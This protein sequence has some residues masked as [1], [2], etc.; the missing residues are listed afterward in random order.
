MLQ[1]IISENSGA[2]EIQ[3]LN[4]V[5]YS[6]EDFRLFTEI[7]CKEVGLNS[8]KKF[9]ELNEY[10]PFSIKELIKSLSN[11]ITMHPYTEISEG[12]QIY[13]KQLFEVMYVKRLIELPLMING[14][15][16]ITPVVK[17]RFRIAK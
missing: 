8:L 16:D 17:W 10:N 2:A 12:A 3:P 13:H 4:N 6:R 9:I 1:T 14:D 7:V 15:P 5:S 11:G